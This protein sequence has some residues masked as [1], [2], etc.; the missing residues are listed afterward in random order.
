MIENDNQK[1]ITKKKLT[2]FKEALASL[3]KRT[4]VHPLQQKLEIDGVKSMI[5]EFE[6][7]LAEYD[8]MQHGESLFNM[9][10]NYWEKKRP[11]ANYVLAVDD[12]LKEVKRAKSIF[13]DNFVNQ[14]EGYAVILEELDELWQEVKKNQRDYDL[15]AQRKEAI[16]CAAMCIRFIAELTPIGYKTEQASA[17]Y[18]RKGCGE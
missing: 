1:E 17:N 12:V 15:A 8:K 10:A 5:D 18:T 13:K 6:K 7:N 16:Q 14:H 2:E 4:D 11:E 3:E 9:A